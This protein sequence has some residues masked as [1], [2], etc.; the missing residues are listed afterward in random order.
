MIEIVMDHKPF[1]ADRHGVRASC[2]KTPARM[3]VTN[4]ESDKYVKKLIY[5]ILSCLVLVVITSVPL[6]AYA[7]PKESFLFPSGP[8]AAQQRQ[9]LFETIAL[10][11]IVAIPVFVGVPLCIW[12][13]RRDGRGL[14]KPRWGLS[15]PLEF[16]VWGVP[17]LIVFALSMLVIGPET[18][19]APDEP[20]AGP[21]PLRVQVVALNWKWLFL[22]PDQHVASVNHLVIP[23]GRPV[24]FFLTS[25][26]TMQSFAI[27][28]LGGQIYAMAGMV[29][30]LNLLADRPGTFAGENTQFNGT[31]FQDEHF[32]VCSVSNNDFWAWIEK[33]RS[34]PRFSGRS[35][36]ILARQ[37][38]SD[39]T[40]RALFDASIL[41]GMP[42]FSDVP[43]DFF[44]T[45][46]NQ[47]NPQV[48]GWD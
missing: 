7:A 28:A 6:T 11:L 22:Y 34:Q 44:M 14:Y 36:E 35:F 37:T 33:L 15:R 45:I 16:I 39:E 43:P 20:L 13:Y 29:T 32:S 9:W 19:F 5:Y 1:S 17:C 2:S 31:G 46:V 12:R 23:A 38:S 18:R 21:P 42:S 24:R 48:L 25:N 41:T 10:L 26:A 4:I 3:H 40:H 30:Q 8:I 27:P 47:Y